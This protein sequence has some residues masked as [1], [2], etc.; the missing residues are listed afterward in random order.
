MLKVFIPEPLPGKLLLPLLAGMQK[1]DNR[2]FQHVPQE[3]FAGIIT[4]VPNPAE[5]DVFLLPHNHAYLRD[6]MD[7]VHEALA[8]ARAAGKR[9]V[10]FS[11]QDDPAPI[12]LPGAIIFRASSYRSTLLPNEI[13]MPAQVEDMGSA[14]GVTPLPKGSRPTVGFAGKAGFDRTRDR[15]RYYV[16]NYLFR[17]GPHREGLFFRRRA[18]ALLARDPR[19]AL[20]AIVRKRFSAHAKTIEVAPD[21]ARAEYVRS[22]QESLFTL[23]PRGDANYSLRFYETLSLGRIPVLIDTDMTLPLEDRIAY[24]EF[25]VRI[26]WNELASLGDRLVDFFES[27]TEEEVTRMQEKARAAFTEFLYLPAFLRQE[28]T[29]EKLLGTTV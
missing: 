29:R 13:P 26:P 19:I 11:V 2:L 24:D 7:Y 17:H 8:A 22:I 14:Y 27:H 23:A 20:S 10:V 9:L 6:R 18:L 21:T 5:A 4:P 3:A 1:G 16:R 12:R 28:M 15:I 25:I